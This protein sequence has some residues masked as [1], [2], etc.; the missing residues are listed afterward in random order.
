MTAK[1]KTIME[2]SIALQER[3]IDLKKGFIPYCHCD[4]EPPL[5][6]ILSMSIV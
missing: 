1:V 5:G 3:I 2:M 6:I 4:V